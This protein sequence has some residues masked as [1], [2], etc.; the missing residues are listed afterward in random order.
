VQLTTT[1]LTEL[2]ST[3]SIPLDTVQVNPA[4][5]VATVALNAV[6][7]GIGVENV[8]VVAPT[9]GLT[10][11]LPLAAGSPAAAAASGQAN[12]QRRDGDN[13][14]VMP[15]ALPIEKIL[16]GSLFLGRGE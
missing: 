13:R 3:T 16:V 4:G 12:G 1:L 14:G 9:A 8:N 7:A 10:V 5:C 2:V 6:S 15:D 11:T